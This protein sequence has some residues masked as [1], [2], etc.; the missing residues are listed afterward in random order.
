MFPTPIDAAAFVTQVGSN[1]GTLGIGGILL[2]LIGLG[3]AIGL[4]W[5]RMKPRGV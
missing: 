4:L 1:F 3:A 5:R 2:G